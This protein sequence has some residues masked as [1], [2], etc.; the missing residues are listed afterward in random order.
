M[1]ADLVR[2]AAA[3]D[4]ERASRLASELGD[5]P[6]AVLLGVAF[7]PLTPYA[8]WQ[9]DAVERIASLGW[10]SGRRRGEMLGTLRTAF[11][12]A[13]SL[14]ATEAL[15]AFRRAVW[16]EKVRVALRELLPAELGGAEIESTARELSLLADASLDV[17]LRE[18]EGQVAARHGQPR[19][20][21][22]SPSR[23]VVFGMGKL[24]GLELNAGSDVDL[25]FVYDTDEGASEVSLHEHWTRV[26]RRSVETL[27]SPTEDGLVWRVDLRL[28]PEGSQ[29]AIVNSVDA[30]ER[31]YVTWGRLWE[32]AALV[33]TRPAAGD[34]ALGE[35][36]ERE[37]VQPFVYRRSIDT[38]L[39][40]ALVELVERQRKELSTDAQRDLKLGPGGIREAETFVQAL[41]LVWGGREPSVRVKNTHAA[42]ARL[43]SRGLVS[44]GEAQA[45]G[46]GYSLLRRLEHRV[47]WM[48]GLQTHLLPSDEGEL[49][50]LGRTLRLAGGAELLRAVARV[51]EAIHER[52]SELGPGRA[53]PASKF[54]PLAA[55]FGADAA[56]FEAAVESAFGSDDVAEHL[57]A[58]ARHPNDPFGVVS[59]ER[60]PLL[61]V[62][63][64]EELAASADPEQAA[65]TLRSFFSRFASPEPYVNA[66]A[67]DRQALR[68]LVTAFASSAFIGDAVIARPELAD[69][70]LFGGGAISDP[71][72]AVEIEIDVQAERLRKSDDADDQNQAL[73][74][75][76]RIAKQRV[77]IEV[78]VA[79]LAGTIGTREATRLLS[80][81]ADEELARA[82]G[83]VMGDEPSGLAVIAMGKLG[84]RDIGYGSDLDVIFVYDPER[85]P[86]SDDAGD[87]FT[88]RA[89]RI[90]FLVSEPHAAGPG[91]DLDTRLRPSGSQGMLVTSIDAF[92]RYHGLS[93]D[94]QKRTSIAPGSALGAR[95]WERQALVRARFAAG[96]AALGARAVEIAERVAYE[97]PAPSPEEVHRL[98][99]RM[100]RELGRE[101]PERFDLKAGR[102]G[103]LDVE[104]CVQL[105]QMQCG[106]DKS[107]RTPD[108][109]EAL[110]ALG[111]AGHLERRDYE[112]FREGYRFLRRLEQRMHVLRGSSS[113]VIVTRGPGMPE[114]ARRMGYRDTPGT[115][116][117]TALLAR[118]RDVTGAVRAA[119][120]RVLGLSPSVS[121]S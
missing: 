37:V 106:A 23:L 69:V 86:S 43:R 116:A 40:A 74:N 85:A 53:R 48:S 63:V 98:R 67:L 66:I 28:R 52:F 108:T 71:S 91:Y 115:P 119:Y 68:R 11:E 81:L 24:G 45:I 60:H 72:A 20:A 5:R 42:L 118:Y 96:D 113:S 64:L 16:T 6:L 112:A 95:A 110:E 27:E 111:A 47:Q 61:A 75:G 78:A 77:M 44:D 3:I 79:D 80:A 4:A 100:E 30:T 14:G 46:E 7:P 49:D 104:L 114:L 56:A 59:L 57:A 26:V 9:A 18:A 105:V 120:E 51:R 32:R 121:P 82:L 76:L 102:G 39:P 15:S 8:G 36:V 38:S 19:R 2:L 62:A 117:V 83:S 89:Q 90:I 58:L 21:D 25:I 29:G 65:R 70:I 10:R 107:V 50:R 109:G 33:R 17:A 103:L 93:L 54:E 84:G 92:A 55:L 12:R 87:F 88:R 41:Q 1:Q 94:G 99:E 34:L 13:R 97:T 101:T 31:Y 73:V 22:G 35:L